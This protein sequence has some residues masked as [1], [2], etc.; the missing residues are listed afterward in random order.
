VVVFGRVLIQALMWTVP[1]EV[2]LVVTQ[3]SAGVFLIVDQ[4]PVG[5]LGSDAADEPLG[6]RVG[7]GVRG[8]V[9]RP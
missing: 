8:G 7:R 9:Y 2:V 6:E 4:R 1:V 5:A 3:H